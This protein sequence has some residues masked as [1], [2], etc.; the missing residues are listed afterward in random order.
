MVA[1][2]KNAGPS[3]AALE[4]FKNEFAKEFGANSLIHSNKIEPYQVIPTGSIAL[5]YAL[6][7]GGIVIGR[8]TEIWGPDGVAKT[9]LALILAAQAQKAHPGKL[10]AYLDMENKLD[11]AWAQKLGVDLTRLIQIPVPSAEVLADQLRKATSSGL[12]SLV[13]VDSIGS[14]VNEEEK[15]KDAGERSVGTTPA[16]ITRMVKIAATE[17]KDHQVAIFIINQVRANLGYGA[18][19]TTGGGF[20]LKHVT[21]HRIKARKASGAPMTIGSGD[22]SEQAAVKIALKVEKNG[23]ATPGRTAIITLVT[24]PSQKY[25]L[26]VGIANLAQEAFDVGKKVGVIPRS[27]ANYTLPDGSVVRG[28]EKAVEALRESPELLEQLRVKVVTAAQQSADEA[29]AGEDNDDDE[30]S[31]EAGSDDDY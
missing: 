14:M 5:D 11:R 22:Q 15:E 31:D 24:K 2:K 13:I 27:G 12:F 29:Q 1:T 17:A 30:K 20:A 8:L 18:D 26:Q 28:E 7:V 23:V 21:T 4:K 6:G 16:I 10:V 19:T 9:T 25:G 3:E